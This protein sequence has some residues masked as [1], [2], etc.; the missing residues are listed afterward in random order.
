MLVLVLMY[1]IYHESLGC[2]LNIFKNLIC[3]LPEY[4]EDKGKIQ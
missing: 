1:H 4:L 2:H 3:G